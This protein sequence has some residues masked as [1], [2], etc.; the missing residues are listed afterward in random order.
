MFNKLPRNFP[1]G[2]DV[3]SVF[4][5]PRAAFYLQNE[6]ATYDGYGS[7]ILKLQEYFANLTER[8]WAQNLYWLWLYSLF[9]LLAPPTDGYPGFMLSEAWLDKALMTTMGSWAE[10]RHDTILYAKQSYTV[11]KGAPGPPAVKK[12]YVE[13]Y[14]EVYSRL[15]SLVHLMIEGLETRGLMIADFNERFCLLAEIFDRLEEISI[16]ELQNNPLNESD[17]SFIGIV[18]EQ[19]CNITKFD[20]P[21]FQEWINEADTRMAIIADVHTDPNSK[22]VL[23]VG[24]GNPFI[25]YVVVQDYD[26]QLYLTKGGTYSYYEF[27][28]PMVDR[29]TDEEWHEMLDENPPMLPDWVLNVLPLILLERA[30]LFSMDPGLSFLMVMVVFPVVLIV[31]WMFSRRKRLDEK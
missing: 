8:D 6:N 16:K 28:R 29:L 25:I 17:F 4:G 5:S 31:G 12:G 23:E 14:P 7:Q 26:G 24:T 10:L 18:A 30:S 20:D 11:M 3:F 9:P 27:K 19:I 21:V 2:L 1:V 13:P 22:A 15:S